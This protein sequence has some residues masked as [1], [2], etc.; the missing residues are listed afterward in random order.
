MTYP[1][2]TFSPLNAPQY[3]A[4]Q[5]LVE[6]WLNLQAAADPDKVVTLEQVRQKLTDLS[7]DGK[8]AQVKAL[9][10]KFGAKTLGSID[11]KHY[12]AVLAE[13]GAL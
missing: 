10:E 2:T 1:T 9:L 6:N 4:V 12:R 13:A 7:R 8:N 5:A 3:Q 11:A